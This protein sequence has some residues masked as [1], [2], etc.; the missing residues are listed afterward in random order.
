MPKTN[1]CGGVLRQLLGSQF[2]QGPSRWLMTAA[3][4][5]NA[6]SKSQRSSRATQGAGV[7]KQYSDE[8]SWLASPKS[9]WWQARVISWLDPLFQF[10]LC[11]PSTFTHLH[12]VCP[13]DGFA[14]NVGCHL[15]WKQPQSLHS[16]N[17]IHNAPLLFSYQSKISFADNNDCLLMVSKSFLLYVYRNVGDEVEF[18]TKIVCHSPLLVEN[19]Q[20]TL[21]NSNMDKLKLMLHSNALW[22]T[23]YICSIVKCIL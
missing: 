3:N 17:T 9:F 8:S 11:K 15:P 6:G 16:I 23:R 12:L 1:H 7:R 13:S 5:W 20:C 10:S 14:N 22:R 18:G 2:A 4:T 21:F 19:M